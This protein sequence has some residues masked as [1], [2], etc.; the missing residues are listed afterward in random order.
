MSIYIYVDV[1]S[2]W[3]LARRLYLITSKKSRIVD[4]AVLFEERTNRRVLVRLGLFLHL[5]SLPIVQFIIHLQHNIA[6]CSFIYFHW[7]DIYFQQSKQFPNQKSGIPG[8]CQA[9]I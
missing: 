4:S 9:N 8:L 2:L 5:V 1:F 6:I 3:H 7:N